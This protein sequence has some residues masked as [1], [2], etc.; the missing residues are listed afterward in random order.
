M[1]VK[2]AE[3]DRALA[4]SLQSGRGARLSGGSATG[5]IPACA[6]RGQPDGTGPRNRERCS[7]WLLIESRHL[8]R[9]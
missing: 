9:V 6:Q 5:W 7:P 1:A 2:V 8:R 3:R 4:P